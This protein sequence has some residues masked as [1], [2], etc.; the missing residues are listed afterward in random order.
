MSVK[1][2]Y[3]YLGIYKNSIKNHWSAAIMIDNE[4][5]YLGKFDS[6]KEALDAF[7]TSANLAFQD[8]KLVSL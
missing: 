4:Y 7:N 3:H 2:N 6:F 5:N 1:K 8:K